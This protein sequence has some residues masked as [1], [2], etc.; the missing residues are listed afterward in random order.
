MKIFAGRFRLFLLVAVVAF[1]AAGGYLYRIFFGP[2]DFHGVREK[3]F[4]VS[5]GQVFPSIVD[6]LISQ[7]VVRSKGEFIFVAK[8]YGG[9][10]R[11]QVGKYLFPDGVS[12]AEIFL[13]L[14]SGRGNS[15]V[16]ITIPEGSRSR[17]QARIFAR[18]IGI[19]SA[20]FINLVRDGSF[21]RLLGIDTPSLE[22]YLL[23]QTYGFFWQ[24]DERDVIRRQVD[25]FKAF[26]TDSMQARARE[27]GFSTNQ[28]VTLASIVEGEAVLDEE[29]PIIAGVYMNRLRKKMKLEADPTIQFILDDGPRRILYSDLHADSPYNTYRNTGLPPGP[30]SN[31]GTASLRA[32][33]FAT[34]HSYLFFVANGKGGHWFTTNYADHLR[35][36]RLYR[37]QR[38]KNQAAALVR[39]RRLEMLNLGRSTAGGQE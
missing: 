4:F 8:V 33:L 10:S 20:K 19:D 3:T 17:A 1:V 12:N 30:V 25:Q 35:Y 11:L 21:A 37:R 31:P 36:V 39:D 15:L 13:T 7:G 9:A 34:Q 16:T 32:V 24:Q 23:P 5:K 6:S 28:L 29:R 18:A 14:R 38:A 2:N 27:I 26:Y 22:G